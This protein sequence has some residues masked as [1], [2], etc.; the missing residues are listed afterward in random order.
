[1]LS[2]HHQATKDQAKDTG[3]AFTLILLLINFWHPDQRLLGGAVLLVLITMAWPTLLKPLAVLWFGLS[4]L[5][6]TVLSKVLLTL[7]FFGVVCPVAF[8]RRLMGIDSL[9]LK[10]W[11]QGKQSVFR[12]R[13]HRFSGDDLEKPY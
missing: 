5:L 4:H 9:N 3:M 2:K 7:V 11:K 1:M 10:G 8:A 13:A 6:G 12:D